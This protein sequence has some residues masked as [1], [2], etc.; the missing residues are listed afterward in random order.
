MCNCVQSV[1]LCICS[2]AL[3]IYVSLYVSR[4]HDGMCKCVN[5]WVGLC[6]YRGVGMTLQVWVSK[7]ACLIMR[8]SENV[9]VSQQA[10]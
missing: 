5:V 10:C 6:V 8:L 9:S 2:W 3:W 7:W 4:P 1:C